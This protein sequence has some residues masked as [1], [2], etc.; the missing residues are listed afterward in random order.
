VNQ[1]TSRLAF[2][3]LLLPA[4]ATIVSCS[5]KSNKSVLPAQS[6]TSPVK[7]PSATSTTQTT[8]APKTLQ[9]QLSEYPEKEVCKVGN[10]PA[11]RVEVGGG[12]SLEVVRSKS[13]I[14]GCDVNFLNSAG[15]KVISSSGPGVK[16]SGATGQDVTGDG[17]PDIVFT[18]DWGGSG[19]F[20][21]TWIYSLDP[22]PRPLFA[23][24]VFGGSQG[25]SLQICRP[26][27]DSES[28]TAYRFPGTPAI[29]ESS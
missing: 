12:F 17:V 8:P 25:E 15:E 6:Q 27:A 10:P 4:A 28:L 20:A 21:S 3:A 9:Q 26:I 11:P 29:A 23:T 1:M 2:F 7:E 5:S 13:D 16:L 18:T 14:N 19:G 24:S 22:K